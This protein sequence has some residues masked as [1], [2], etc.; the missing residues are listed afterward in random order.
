MSKQLSLFSIAQILE[1]NSLFAFNSR[2]LVDLLKIDAVQAS[3]ILAR[4]SEENLVV[5]VERGKYLLL[6]LAPERV[7]SNPLFIGSQ[8]TTPAYVSFW[9]GLHFY[10]FTEQVPTMVQLVVTRRKKAI[11]FQ[12][13]VYKFITVA[14]G[15]FFGYRREILGELPVVIADKEKTIIDSLN[16]PQ[17]AGGVSEV[18]KALK[19]AIDDLEILT[20]V[21]YANR[22][23]NRSLC[24]RLG[25]L[26]DLLG[27]DPQDIDKPKGP[28][29]LDP[30][31]PRGG[32]YNH[33]WQI[34][35]NIPQ[36]ELFPEGVG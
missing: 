16:K 6:G 20:L 36:D 31:K 5:Q 28:V 27:L 7:L 17:H 13:T 23:E 26:L 14:P 11:E 25:Y 3:K 32:E 1:G 35:A 10:G 15:Q 8:L 4:M 9:S 22:M 30:A 12:G 24:S 33:R 29:S 34:Y 2:T 18:A 19:N 21:E